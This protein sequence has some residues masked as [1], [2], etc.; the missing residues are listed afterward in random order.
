MRDAGEV[1]YADVRGT[2]GIVEYENED[3]MR[4]ALKKLDDT[5][6]KTFD[7]SLTVTLY[8]PKNP[9]RSQSTILTIYMTITHLSSILLSVLDF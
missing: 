8:H 9:C 5:E 4:Y 1:I 6:L 7:V 3:D 2:A